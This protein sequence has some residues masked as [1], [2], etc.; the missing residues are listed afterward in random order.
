MSE[1]APVAEVTWTLPKQ[2]RI[3]TRPFSSEALTFPESRLETRISPFFNSASE[4]E[5]V[6]G[7]TRMQ[8]TVPE[9]SEKPQLFDW[10][11]SVLITIEFG[12]ASILTAMTFNRAGL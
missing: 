5:H 6:A 2:F 8:S 9:R 11:M 10:G 4:T 7:T 12:L 1:T 3:K